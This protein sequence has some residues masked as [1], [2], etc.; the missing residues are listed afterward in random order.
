MY[1]SDHFA[2]FVEM[3]MPMPLGTALSKPLLPAPPSELAQPHLSSFNTG[4]HIPSSN[5]NNFR[6]MMSA[7]LQERSLNTTNN[8]IQSMM[9][10]PA[11]PLQNPPVTTNHPNISTNTHLNSEGG[12]SLNSLAVGG[13][14]SNN[15]MTGDRKEEFIFIHT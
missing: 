5:T 14:N 12:G 4:N 8:S 11:G 10:L 3:A 7:N 6:N 13:R 15:H 1:F 2:L 9:G